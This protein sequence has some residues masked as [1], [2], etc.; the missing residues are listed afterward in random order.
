MRCKTC[1]GTGIDRI[2]VTY[3]GDYEPIP[4]DCT[5]DP[6]QIGDDE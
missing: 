1:K 3:E 5:I 2:Q 4:C 6:E